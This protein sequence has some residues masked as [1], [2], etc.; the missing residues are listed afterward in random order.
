MKLDK[1]QLSLASSRVLEVIKKAAAVDTR[2]FTVPQA[3]QHSNDEHLERVDVLQA[4]FQ[5]KAYTVCAPAS[6][7]AA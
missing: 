4:G 5:T 7:Y 1:T 6:R 2:C 3:G